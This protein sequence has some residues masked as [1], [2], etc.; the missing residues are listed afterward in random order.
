V[1]LV[2]IG[3]SWGGLQAIEIVLGRLPADYG[4]AVVIAQHRQDDGRAG[5]LERAAGVEQALAPGAVVVAPAG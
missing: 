2:A 4:A 1:D 3:A 5:A